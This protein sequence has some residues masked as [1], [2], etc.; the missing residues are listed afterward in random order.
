[1]KF[2]TPFIEDLLDRNTKNMTTAHLVV[3]RVLDTSMKAYPK[4]ELVY[5]EN[6]KIFQMKLT[7]D[8][9]INI[10]MDYST[11]SVVIA[12]IQNDDFIAR[13]I[14]DQ[15]GVIDEVYRKIPD[16]QLRSNVKEYFE[17]LTN[18]DFTVE[19]KITNADDCDH[20]ETDDES[21][22]HCTDDTMEEDD[23][24]EQ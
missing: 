14:I 3:D 1:M 20:G 12:F 18:I 5:D 11:A 19:P 24:N 7:E 13:I 8:I 23:V 17:L 15:E 21:V 4:A 9:R 6:S 22:I 16:K 10:V 2:Y